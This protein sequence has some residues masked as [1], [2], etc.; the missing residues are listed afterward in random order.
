MR[1]LIWLVMLITLGL[2]LFWPHSS[3]LDPNVEPRCE[4]Q[5]PRFC[6][7]PYHVEHGNGRSNVGNP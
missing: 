3:E 1:N 2:W 5:T 7:D 4:K 6:P